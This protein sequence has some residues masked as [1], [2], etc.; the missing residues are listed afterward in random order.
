[1]SKPKLKI[2]GKFNTAINTL[3][4]LHL[5]EQDIFRSSGLYTHVAK[6]NHL[7]SLKYVDMI[8]DILEKPDYIG[9]N[10]NESG[11]SLEYLKIIDA[12]VI[13][14]GVKYDDKDKHLYVSTMH[15]IPNKRVP[16][17]LR[18]GRIK[19]YIDIPEVLKY[20]ND[21]ENKDSDEPE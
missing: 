8:P 14:V 12:K 11:I 16:R 10:P 5:E 7:N 18:D 19:T 3:L 2:V 1:M 9:I 17:N 15:Q 4:G 13:L 20:Y 21:I 6:H